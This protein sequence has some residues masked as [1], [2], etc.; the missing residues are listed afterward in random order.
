[1]KNLQLFYTNFKKFILILFFT[2]L[3][4]FISSHIIYYIKTGHGFILGDWLINYDNS[5]KRRG[6]LGSCFLI[7]QDL[8]NLRLQTLAIILQITLYLCFSVFLLILF[9]KKNV[10]IIFL[11]LI[12][13]PFSFLFYLNDSESIGRKEIILFLLFIIFTFRITKIKTKSIEKVISVFLIVLTILIHEMAFFYIPYFVIL[14]LIKYPR[15]KKF[16]IIIFI[17]ASLTITLLFFYG[18]QINSIDS[19]N[20]LKERG[21]LL[22]PNNIFLFECS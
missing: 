1:M 12:F 3:F 16:P 17:S 9:V 8:T 2:Y 21:V 7:I 6:L 4:F 19:L 22:Q 11:S 15:D 18:N 20:L 13:S 5:F 14:Y 10:D